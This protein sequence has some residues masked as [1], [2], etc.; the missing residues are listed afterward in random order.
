MTFICADNGN[1][2][3]AW[4]EMTVGGRRRKDYAAREPAT[5]A[6]A[7]RSVVVVRFAFM[8]QA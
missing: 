1:A 2:P 6:R 5:E 8:E 4:V 7:R 3:P